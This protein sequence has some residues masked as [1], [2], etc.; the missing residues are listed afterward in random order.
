MIE[1]RSVLSLAN[2][3]STCGDK[4]LPAVIHRRFTARDATVGVASVWHA[5]LDIRA[6]R[7]AGKKTGWL[8]GYAYASGS[9]AAAAR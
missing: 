4:V 3:I 9:A 1:W 8:L 7:L 2:V 6:D 5:H